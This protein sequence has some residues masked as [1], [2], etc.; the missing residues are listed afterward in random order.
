MDESDLW[1]DLKRME[2]KRVYDHL[3]TIL[4]KNKRKFKL[5]I[6]KIPVVGK[7]IE[8]Y[9]MLVFLGIALYN[10]INPIIE[11]MMQPP[12]EER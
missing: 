10:F 12:E 2:W 7:Y 4:R 3:S 11:F 1:I 5:L 9:G 6:R 8:K